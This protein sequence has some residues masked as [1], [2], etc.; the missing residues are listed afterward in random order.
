VETREEERKRGGGGWESVFGCWVATC[1]P[2]FSGRG[3]WSAGG[4]AVCSGSRSALGARRDEQRGMDGMDASEGGVRVWVG[5]GKTHVQRGIEKRGGGSGGIYTPAPWQ[6]GN[7]SPQNGLATSPG[8]PLSLK[9]SHA[10]LASSPA[11]F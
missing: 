11:P 7:L 4:I 8:S 1:Y 9:R 5:D 10:D 2:S 3:T 6:W